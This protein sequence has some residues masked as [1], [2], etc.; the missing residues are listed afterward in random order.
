MPFM[1]AGCFS[2]KKA[3]SISSSRMPKGSNFSS[4]YNNGESVV[5]PQAFAFVASNSKANVFFKISTRELKNA[6]A[7]P[8]AN[9]IGLYVKYFL[10][11]A[12]NFQLADT[13]SMRF[14]LSVADSEYVYGNF[15][16]D[17]PQ[18]ND[19]KLIVDFVNMQY[20]IRKRLLLDVKNT[21]EFN[22]SK[23]YLRNLSGEVLFSNVVPKGESVQIFANENISETLAI[24][25]YEAKNYIC[26]PP[27]VTIG[28][29][30]NDPVSS[31]NGPDSV[32]TYNLTDTIIFDK[33]GFYAIGST[34]ENEK[35][36]I[37][38]TENASFPEIST[39]N[40]MCE[41]VK[42][43]ATEREYRVI[44]SATNKKQA[45]DAFWLG[46]SKDERMAKEQI[47]VFYNRVAMANVFF[48]NTVEGWKT[49]RGMI[50]ILLGPPSIVNIT[51]ETEEWTYGNEQSGALFT[52]VNFSGIKNN[53]SLLREN[54]YQSIWQQVTATWRL[55]RIFT[56]TT[57]DNE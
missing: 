40:D 1:L 48:S 12:D 25:F 4:L 16:V 33:E 13:A 23:Y 28:K 29:L 43:F 50:Y 11:N 8:E 21:A 26:L 47:R 27:Y 20:D 30:R 52:F 56:V 5:N 7:N 31:S 15:V 55:G 34:S 41:P 2:S 51:Q 32:F 9:E 49:D 38:V 36:G 45:I 35:F 37:V 39:L 57:I 42:L 53:Y 18:Q 19:Y 10:R 6:L 22:D 3:P 14:N 24:E 46:L 54:T 17:L 44:D